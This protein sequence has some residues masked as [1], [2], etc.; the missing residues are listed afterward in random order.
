M[1]VQLVR[2]DVSDLVLRTYCRS[3][4]P[5]LFERH[6]GLT[7][8]NSHMRLDI[9][10]NASR[11]LSADERRVGAGRPPRRFVCSTSCRQPFTSGAPQF[12]SN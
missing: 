8:T 4:H 3:L 11:H 9:R 6:C 2:P 12:D 7:L 1:A 10:L 5:E